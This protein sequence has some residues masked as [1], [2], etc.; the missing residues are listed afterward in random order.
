MKAIAGLFGVKQEGPS[1]A[2]KAAQ[3]DQQ[4]Q[5]NRANAEADAKVALA[6]RATSLRRSL[7]YND[8]RKATLGG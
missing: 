4:A 3:T 7:A 1:A 6:S 5:A 2:E 8:Q